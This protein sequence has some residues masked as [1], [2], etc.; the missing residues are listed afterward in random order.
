M[1]VL[2]A[3]TYLLATLKILHCELVDLQLLLPDNF[4]NRTYYG[5]LR[6]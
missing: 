1:A 3:F 4:H 2:G 5:L 6:N